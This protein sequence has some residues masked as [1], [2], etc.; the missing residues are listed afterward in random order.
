MGFYKM[1]GLTTPKHPSHQDPPKFL[2]PQA[3]QAHHAQTSTKFSHSQPEATSIAL[4]LPDVWAWS[5]LGLLGLPCCGP[6]TNGR[7]LASWV[8]CGSTMGLPCR[9]FTQLGG[10]WLHEC[11]AGST[12]SFYR[13]PFAPRRPRWLFILV[14]LGQ[15]GFYKMI[16]LTLYTTHDTKTLLIYCGLKQ[17][18]PIQPEA[19]STAPCP[20]I[21]QTIGTSIIQKLGELDDL[22]CLGMVWPEVDGLA[23]LGASSKQLGGYWLYGCFGGSTQSF[24]PRRPR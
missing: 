6:Q 7:V 18:K 11:R 17:G 1:T 3:G 15:M 19:T 2:W 14:F 16:G 22:R 5:G 4:F 20:S 21:D 23:L 8:R 13:N 9:G 12:Q 24:A 10:R